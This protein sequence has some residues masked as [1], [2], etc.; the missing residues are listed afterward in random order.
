MFFKRKKR[1]SLPNNNDLKN[2][3]N[4]NNSSLSEDSMPVKEILNHTLSKINNC[5]FKLLE[6]ENTFTKSILKIK[7]SS[8]EATHTAEI[9]SHSTTIINENIIKSS[10]ELNEVMDDLHKNNIYL[11]ECS[12]SFNTL[13]LTIENTSININ[14]FKNSFNAL[15]NNVNKVNNNLSYINEISDQTNLLAL[16]ASIEAAHA[17][18]DGK[19][20]AIVAQEVRNLAEMTNKTSKKIDSEL[21]EINQTIAIIK[22]SVDEIIQSMNNTNSSIDTTISNFNNLEDSNNTIANNITSNINNINSLKNNI[23]DIQSSVNKNEKNSNKVLE[24]VANLSSLGT[25]KPLIFHHIQC[26]LKGIEDLLN[27]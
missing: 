13:K 23:L 5:I 24:L 18:D 27:R 17:G 10:G 9:I 25:K 12:T 22:K 4:S 21:Q 26:Y 14:G 3:D 15:E 8:Q 7:D 20:F 16:N 2:I 11:N 19:G 6:I 1:D